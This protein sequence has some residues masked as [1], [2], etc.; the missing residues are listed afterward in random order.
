MRNINLLF[1]LFFIQWF[2]ETFFSNSVASVVG[3][4]LIISKSKRIDATNAGANTVVSW[5]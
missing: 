3:L 2:S 4:M 5:Q 1:L